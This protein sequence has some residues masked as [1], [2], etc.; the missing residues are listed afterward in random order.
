MLATKQPFVVLIYVLSLCVCAAF[1]VLAELIYF[2]GSFF[3]SFYSSDPRSFMNE[4]E[5]KKNWSYFQERFFDLRSVFF[6]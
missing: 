6:L 2:H 1:A 5:E 3:F 4:A